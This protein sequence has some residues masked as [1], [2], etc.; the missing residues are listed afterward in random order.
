MME[1]V[2]TFS[3]KMKRPFHAIRAAKLWNSFPVGGGGGK[4]RERAPRQSPIAP[5]R[6]EM[7]LRMTVR[8]RTQ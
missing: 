4:K 1:Q 3:L 2:S 6:D 5:Q 7:S 8:D